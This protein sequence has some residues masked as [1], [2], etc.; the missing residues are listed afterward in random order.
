[1]KTVYSDDHR[2]QD[3][4]AELTN[5]QLVPC[6]EKPKRADLVLARVREVRLGEVVTPTDYG[7]SAIARV[8]TDPFITFLEH[9]WGE[10]V[11]EH[12][13]YDA[14][15]LTWPTRTLRQDRVPD[16]IDGKLSYYSLDAGT[17]IT[18]GTW[19]AISSA[20][21]VAVTGADLLRS[22][23]GVAFSLCRPPGHHASFDVYGGYCFFNNAAI[24][25]QYL[26]DNGAKKV[27]VL[28]V[29]YHHGNGTQSI[30]YA[31]ADVPFVSLHGDPRQEYPYFLG[32]DDELGVGDGLGANRNFPMP[33]GTEWSAYEVALVEGIKNLRAQK[34]ESLVV[35][36]GVDTFEGDPISQFKLHHEDYLRM[37][38]HIASLG[39]PTLF[40]FE[41]GYA[42]DAI[43]VNAVNVLAGFENA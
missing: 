41:G 43:G 22:G 5:G 38:A 19:R 39:L 10:W 30:F 29:D 12:G 36:L 17:P 15:P 7:R 27:G 16:V 9:A 35:S 28:D 37:G 8:H 23:E 33:W 20:V 42:V 14:L 21:N 2:L 26:I 34:I 32:Y 6:F 24:A 18:S 11:A 3:G 1:M 4:K 13:E 25:T 40:V 31:R